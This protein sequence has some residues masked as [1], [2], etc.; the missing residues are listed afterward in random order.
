ML[1]FG[2]NLFECPQVGEVEM[3]ATKIHFTIELVDQSEGFL[4][5]NYC[6]ILFNFFRYGPA[7]H[8]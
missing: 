4:I 2:D 5:W 6:I 1:I 7:K 8:F 3:F